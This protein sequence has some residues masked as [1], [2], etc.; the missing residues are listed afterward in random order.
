MQTSFKIWRIS[1]IIHKKMVVA[2]LF[3]KK[4]PKTHCL[5]NT[6]DII[7]IYV[8]SKNKNSFPLIVGGH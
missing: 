1:S 4:K 2:S 6:F 7:A 3:G 8:E 5:C